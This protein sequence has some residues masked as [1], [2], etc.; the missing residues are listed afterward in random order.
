MSLPLLMDLP[1]TDGPPPYRGTWAFSLLMDL[2]LLP[3]DE[4]PPTDGSPPYR[5]TCSLLIDLGLLPTN[6]PPPY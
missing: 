3:T 4:S 5:W 6:G 1:H 2:G